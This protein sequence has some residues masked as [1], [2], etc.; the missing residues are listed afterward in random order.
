MHSCRSALG[1]LALSTTLLA[2]DALTGLVEPRW[3]PV[4]ANGNDGMFHFVMDKVASIG[5]VEH[6]RVER[7]ETR[8][9]K[10]AGGETD[11]QTRERKVRVVL[12]RCEGK[13]ICDAIPFDGD[14]R[15]IVV[16]PKAMGQTTV[17]VTAVLDERD[18][19]KDSF[20]IHVQ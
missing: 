14:T 12:A 10:K 6:V 7:S 19:V 4:G 11:T 17:Y 16:T 1:G 15:E 5:H 20:T 18:E 3:E 8:A 2:C 13:S 9:F